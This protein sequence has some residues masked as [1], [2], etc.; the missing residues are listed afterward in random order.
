ME[1]LALLVFAVGGFLTESAVRNRNPI[2][3]GKRVLNE[4]ERALALASE[5]AGTWVAP[6]AAPT[7]VTGTGSGSGKPKTDAARN[8][9]LNASELQ[10]LS[11][12]RSERLLPQ[13]ASAF[14]ALNMAF[15]AQFGRNI[16]VTDSYRTLA[17]QR[18]LR[19]TKGRMAAV[20]GTS[21]H[22]LGIAVDLGGGINNWNTPE[23]N[24]FVAYAPRFGWISPAWA[25]Q[26]GDK[27]EPW[28]WEYVGT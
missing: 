23:R 5:M 20:P 21:L 25:Q 2:E 24:W 26:G 22:G 17:S 3:Y 13:A 14:E 18:T 10:T 16:A 7:K 8:G 11:W 27:P 4:P 1:W 15:R 28:H 19:A 12:D 6:T 9:Q